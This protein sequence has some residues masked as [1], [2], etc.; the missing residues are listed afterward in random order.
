[1]V[2]GD[3]LFLGAHTALDFVNTRTVDRGRP[4]ER[5]V[6]FE[7]LLRFVRGTRLL[8]AADAEVAFLRWSAAPERA[9]VVADA[10]ALREAIRRWLHDANAFPAVAEVVEPWLSHAPPRLRLARPEGHIA[11]QV[12]VEDGPPT[13]LLRAL[14]IQAAALLCDVD[15]R[16]I[17]RC[18]SND[19]EA[20]FVVAGRTVERTWCSQRRCGVRHRSAVYEA[21]GMRRRF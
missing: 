4:V 18:A 7:A 15:R 10:I 2:A 1:M 3:F 20:W 11:R 8:P 9:Q 12:W 6:D 14:A 16:A 21:R 19:C 5:L 17:R 13:L